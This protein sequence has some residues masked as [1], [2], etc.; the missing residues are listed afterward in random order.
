MSG[1][2]RLRPGD[3]FADDFEIVRVVAEGGMG[4]IYE[5]RDRTEDRVCALKVLHTQLVADENSRRRFQQESQVSTKV[6]S[7]HVPRVFRS[8]VDPRS[9]TPFISMELLVGRDLRRFVTERGAVPI[10]EAGR[11]FEQATHALAAAHRMGLVHRDLKPENIFLQE[12][13]GP[14]D[15]KLLDFGVSKLLDL[16]RT[17]GTGTG[18][19]G[20]PLWMAPEQTSAG[21]RIAPATDVWAFGLV[22]FYVLT[23]GLY[24]K[25]AQDDSGVAGLLREIHIDPIAKPSI[26]ARELGLHVAL[27]TGYDEWFLQA[28]QRDGGARFVE[29]GVA[30]DAL[31]AVLSPPRAVADRSAAAFASTLEFDSPIQSGPV[32]V[33]VSSPAT[34]QPLGGI[35]LKPPPDLGED[36]DAHETH[37]N[38]PQVEEFPETHRALPI[39]HV[40]TTTGNLP[41]VVGPEAS[42]VALATP[43]PSYAQPAPQFRAPPS[44]ESPPVRGR[45]GLSPAAFVLLLLAGGCF[46]TIL[47]AGL[48]WVLLFVIGA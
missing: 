35:T 40:P 3:L 18:A 22:S 26:R 25:A 37:R 31:R 23:G 9:G 16:H 46:V 34:T 30:M 6:A 8:G 32:P 7:P 19:V 13:G 17:S 15:V 39:L 45:S 10:D 28:M 12:T 38:L 21:G 24:W 33:L 43:Q 36:G 4:T 27:P 20:S 42:P 41:R 44:P 11:I 1:L 47:A 2:I 29:A 5:A 14:P 48:V